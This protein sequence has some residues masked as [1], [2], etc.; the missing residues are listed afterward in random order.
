MNTSI[1]KVLSQRPLSSSRPVTNPASTNM[2]GNSMDLGFIS[3]EAKAAE[4]DSALANSLQQAFHSPAPST[5]ALMNMLLA[6]LG[7][8]RQSMETEFPTMLN[9]ANPYPSGGLVSSGNRNGVSG[10]IVPSSLAGQVAVSGSGSSQGASPLSVSPRPKETPS[11]RQ[12]SSQSSSP[13]DGSQAVRIG[14]GTKVLQI[15]DSHTQGTFG[16]ELDARLRSTGAQVSTYASAGATAATFVRGKPT[17]YGYWE[18]RADGSSRTVGYGKLATTPR[19]DG[20]L[21]REK[22]QVLVVNLGANFRGGQAKGQVA[23][24]GALAQKH[25]IPIIWVGP[26]KTGRDGSN[27]K[28]L[29]R[30]DQTMAA[31]V[32][33][34][35]RYVSS[36]RHTPR[37]SGGD[38]LHYS[39]RVGRQIARRWA[40]GVFQDIVG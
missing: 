35:G 34:Y 14:P 11:V 36:N 1:G 40:A 31:A 2:A 24:I 38:G 15:G 21:A 10:K 26:P 19:L 9:T 23:R 4:V 6:M 32:A 30:F 33:P 27:P 13:P 25:N 29:A 7:L 17:K 28:A 16:K 37:Y 8:F 5:L 3:P 20:L 18:K 22:P 12:A 39:G